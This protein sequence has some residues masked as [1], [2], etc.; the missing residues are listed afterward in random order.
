MAKA[1]F[2]LMEPTAQA[3]IAWFEQFTGRP[4]TAAERRDV[5]TEMATDGQQARA[6]D[7]L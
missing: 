7:E 2:S 6:V 5:E 4:V 3:I 1:E